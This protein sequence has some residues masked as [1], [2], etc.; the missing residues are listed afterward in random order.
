L[1]AAI[2]GDVMKLRVAR[3]TRIPIAIFFIGIAFSFH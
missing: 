1:F 3:T 2:A